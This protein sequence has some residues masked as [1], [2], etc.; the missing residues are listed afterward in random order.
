MSKRRRALL[1]VVSLVLLVGCQQ[2][3]PRVTTI[4]PNQGPPGGGTVI[5]LSGTNL[6]GSSLVFIDS[7]E[8]SNISF[9]STGAITATTPA[10]QLGFAEVTVRNKNGAR[11]HARNGFE[12]TNGPAPVSVTLVSPTT[13]P[14]GTTVTV[15]GSNFQPG[16]QVSFGGNAATNVTV[17][18]PNQLTCTV[19]AGSGA[20]SI[21]VTNGDGGTGT[22]PTGFT[23][24]GGTVT[25]SKTITTF[26]GTGTATF[27]GDGA[28]AT[29]AEL[30]QPQQVAVA[31]D[32]SVVFADTGNNRVR[33]IASG[34]INTLTGNAGELSSP[35]GVALDS[36]G[37]VLISD[38]GHQVVKKLVGTT[39]TV[40]AGTLNSNG[41]GGDGGLATAAQLSSPLG[42]SI[43]G[44]NAVFIADSAN[45]VVRRVDG[46][47][48]VISR[49]AG[50][51]TAGSGGEAVVATTCALNTP[52]GV[53]VDSGG[54][55][56]IADT[57]NARVRK[58]TGGI[59]GTIATFAGGGSANPGDN[60]LA[61]NA[62][63]S[64]PVALGE[65][66]NGGIVIVDAGTNV[67][68]IVSA[69]TI[70]L[71]AGDYNQGSM[72]DGG[73][74]TSAQL[75]GPHGVGVGTGPS[76]F[77]GDTNNAKIRKVQ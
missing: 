76:Y 8:C 37:N 41:P 74:A 30:N 58:V 23:Y 27:G 21:T 44:S 54:S 38:T 1:S 72:G 31:T 66:S 7:V 15:N 32:G 64:Q 53:L 63:L 69:G 3:P 51:G 46:S 68:R 73:L 6:S 17:Q 55:V 49:F 60:G 40:F 19:P 2:D 11:D 10:G 47:T 9:V 16:C 56:Y 22:L 59:G 4:I 70:A 43:D 25:G 39:L 24:P 29:A 26:A 71:L 61:T 13:G 18:N 52:S 67:V 42:L 14:A 34:T 33:K 75:F 48:N 65:D 5:T 62:V 35:R 77:I 45:H 20:V 28:A 36:Q 57:A 12:Y 50:T